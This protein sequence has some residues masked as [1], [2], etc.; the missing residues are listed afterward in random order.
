[1]MSE[2]RVLTKYVGEFVD[3]LAKSGVKKVVISP[4]SRSTPLAILIAEHPQLEYFVLVDERSAAFFAL[5]IAKASNEPVAILCTSGTA[6]ANYYPAIIEAHYARVPIV[7]I[8]ADRPHELRDIGA[9]QAM[10]QVN[11]YGKFVKWFQDLP[12]PEDSDEMIRYVRT[13]SARAVQLTKE[14]PYGPVHINFPLREPLLPDENYFTTETITGKPHVQ[15]KHSLPTLLDEEFERIAAQLP[16]KGL[17]IC[18]PMEDGHESFAHALTNFAEKVQYPI[19][20]DPLSQL[21]SGDHKGKWIIDN[22]DSFL[23]NEKVRKSLKPELILRF[24]AM[25]VSKALLFFVKEHRDVPQY[26]IDPGL[27]WRDPA[28]SAHE[29]IYCDET[30]FC[31]T[32]STKVKISSVENEWFYQWHTLNE[33]TKNEMKLVDQENDINEG[34]IFYHLSELLP[35]HSC[36]FVGNSMPIRDLDS[37]FYLNDRHIKVYANR[38]VNG[39]DG[40]VSSA[41]GASIVNNNT[42]LVIGDL[43]FYHDLNGLLAAK[44]YGLN[45]TIILINNNGGGIFSLLP[46]R[47][48][49]KH[50]ETLFGTPL[51]LQFEYAV[52]MYGGIYTKVETWHEFL[53]SIEKAKNTEGLKVI[54]VLT[55]REKNAQIRRKLWNH[56]SQEIMKYV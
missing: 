41:L 54:E 44:L 22:Y 32:L 17:I 5:G 31:S 56:V 37:F 51:D 55:D 25:P 13:V 21:R 1:M 2:N 50:F 42:Y 49:P 34:K 36:L 39:I 43:S 52:K 9:P 7:V 33:K 26:V 18:G 8:T 12:L 46:Q 28:G 30:I 16:K 35:S 45:I 3:E 11:L 47:K 4:G 40:V 29:I 20:A 23:R 19:L 14:K 53:A 24:G 38:G 10:D 27:G 15:V 6:A 48:V